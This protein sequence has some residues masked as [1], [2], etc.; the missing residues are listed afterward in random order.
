MP[1]E[2]PVYDAIGLGYASRRRPDPRIARELTDALGDSATVLN[3]GAG[4][5]S[6]EPTDR[7]VVAVEPSPVMIGQRPPGAVPA[8][9]AQAERLPFVDR[10][11]DASM[12]VLTVHHWSDLDQGLAELRRVTRGPIVVLTSDLDAL[13]RWWLIDEYAP[14][15]A[16][17]LV[18]TLPSVPRIAARLG[19]AEVRPI[20]VPADCSDV[21]LMA[22]W[23]RPELVLDPAARAATS[24]FA[25]LP[26]AVEERIV[27]QLATDLADGTWDKRHGH[28]RRLSAFGSGL[29]LI[30]AAGD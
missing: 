15:I 30:R 5:G 10:A 26:S 2:Q 7:T 28:L 27:S 19:G 3:V 18:Q 6:Y 21:F 29:R 14:E 16:D 9:I 17:D 25:Q 4:A 20:P 1:A 13:R 12:A 24:G 22:F 11:F 8:V 23:N